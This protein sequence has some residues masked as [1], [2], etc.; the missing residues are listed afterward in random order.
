MSLSGSARA[1]LEPNRT[2]LERL[3]NRCLSTVSNQPERAELQRICREEWQK[4]PKSRSAKLFVSHPRKLEAVIAA[5]GA[6][7]EYWVK[8]LN[9]C[10]N[11]IFCFSFLINL[12]IF[13]CRLK[14]ATY[15]NVFAKMLWMFYSPVC[16]YMCD[17]CNTFLKLQPDHR[18]LTFS[19]NIKLLVVIL[20]FCFLLIHKPTLW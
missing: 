1:W 7:T 10:V 18:T 6:S 3:K 9:T 16:R 13:V 12:L 11:V 14:P 15:Q 4:I 20:I 2:S 5:K 8:G 19:G 17:V